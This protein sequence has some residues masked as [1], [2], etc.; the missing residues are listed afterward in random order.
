MLTHSIDALM[1]DAIARRVFPGAV[2]LVAQ[3]S[4][5]LHH[6]AYGTTMYEDEGSQLVALDTRYDIASLT[7]VFTATAA[8]QLLGE[9]ILA[10]DAPAK[11]YLPELRAND[12]LVR[13][14]L[15]HTSGLALRLSALREGGREALMA[16]VYEALP[17]TP[18]GQH[19]AYTNVNSLLL[20]EIVA[21]LRGAPLDAV[22]GRYVLEPLGM[23]AT[24]FLPAPELRPLIAPTERDDAWRGGL[25]HGSVHD[26]SAHALGGVCGH[27]GMFSTAADLGRFCMAWLA[28]RPPQIPPAIA[29]LATQNHTPGLELAC[30][31]GWMLDRPA[32]MGALAA[33]CYGHTGFTGPAMMLAPRSNRCLVL[34]SNRTYPRRT[35]PAHH[36]VTAQLAE[37]TLSR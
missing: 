18:P 11:R 29:A 21:R 14:L 32:F 10:L 4:E 23:R 9:G 27:A 7:K 16:A 8:L 12:V 15:T 2:L 6:A 31:L 20:G 22:I 19:A 35:P 30:G 26:E 25:V 17:A 36:A 5:I 37:L 3:G 24:G 13:H 34:L 1:R 28:A 33:E